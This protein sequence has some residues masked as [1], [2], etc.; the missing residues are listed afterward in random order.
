MSQQ[1]DGSNPMRWDCRERGCFNYLQRPKI[2]LFA[3]AFPGMNNF[4]DVDGH[5][6][7]CGHFLMLEWKSQPSPIPTGQR[8]AF[9]RRTA[10][11]STIVLVLAGNACTMH[12]THMA[13]FHGGRFF[14]WSESTLEEA[15]T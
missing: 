2:E 1:P 6:E 7:I 14:K 3:K 5:I 10:D 4:G 15:I 13:Y 12:V 9:E 8:I 11:K